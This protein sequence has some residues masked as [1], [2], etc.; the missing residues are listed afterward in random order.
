MDRSLLGTSLIEDL[1][2]LACAAEQ[3]RLEAQPARAREALERV[4][5]VDTTELPRYR[6]EGKLDRREHDL[7]E[8]F[9]SFAHERLAP[10]PRDQDAVAF[11]RADPGWQAVRERALELVTALDAFVDVGVPGWAHQYQREERPG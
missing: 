8:Q 5:W 4:R 11:T 7:I 2:R 9:C 10:I 1:N 6:R 3:E